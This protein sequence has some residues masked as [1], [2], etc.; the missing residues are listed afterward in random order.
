LTYSFTDIYSAENLQLGDH[1][2]SPHASPGHHSASKSQ[3]H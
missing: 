3:Q 1:Y 2:K